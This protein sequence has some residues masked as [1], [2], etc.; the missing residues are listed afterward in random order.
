MG[1]ILNNYGHVT[2][3]SRP[4]PHVNGIAAEMNLQQSQGNPHLLK[5]GHGSRPSTPEPNVNGVQA[6]LNYELARGRAVN[7]L[8]HEYG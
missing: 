4:I 8:F 5:H 1:S 3:P 7:K 6:N 2:P